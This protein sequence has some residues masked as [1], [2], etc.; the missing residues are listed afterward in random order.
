MRTFVM[1][2]IHGA[3]RALVQ[4]LDRAEFDLHLDHLI[5]LGDVCDGWPD[6]KQSIE[7]LLKIKNLTYI[8]GNH[9][10]WTRDWMQTG[11]IND[12]WYNQG[13]KATLQSYSNKVLFSH[14]TFLEKALPYYLQEDSLFVHAGIL[15]L[16]PLEQQGQDI[17]LWDRSLSRIT[18]EGYLKGMTTKLTSYT[19]VYIGHTPT[20]NSKPLHAGGVWM[21]DTGAGWSGVLTMMDINTKEI[22]VSDPVPE[23]YPDVEARVKK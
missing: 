14:L 13:G 17:F 16:R 18:M 15:P 23:L 7:A 9:D 21:M 4:C 10:L 20:P 1:G 11:I 6:T 22:F 19:E 8:L 2:D 3:H 5:C 12:V